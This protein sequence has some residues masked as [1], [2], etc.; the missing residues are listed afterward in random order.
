MRTLIIFL[1]L[2]T[3]SFAQVGPPTSPT[4]E[5][6]HAQ[7]PLT[8]N[9]DADGRDITGV[10]NMAATSFIGDGSG[11]VNV[12]AKL[13]PIYDDAALI[14]S[15]ATDLTTMN[16]A[17]ALDLEDSPGFGDI[18]IHATDS[19]L[20]LQDPDTDAEW[21]WYYFNG[22]VYDYIWF[23]TSESPWL[24]DWEIY[25]LDEANL[26][27][28]DLV[29]LPPTMQ[30]IEVSGLEGD[31]A[32][33]N[34]IYEYGEGGWGQ[35]VET[36]VWG[37]ISLSGNGFAGYT[38][39]ERDET[40]FDTV[41]TLLYHN[42]NVTFSTG[43]TVTT[44][45]WDGDWSSD[46]IT[47]SEDP[48]EE[49]EFHGEGT[50]TVANAFVDIPTL[51]RDFAEGSQYLPRSGMLPMTGDLD[52]GGYDIAGIEDITATG[53]VSLPGVVMDTDEEYTNTVS[54]AGSAVQTNHTGNVEITGTL[55]ASE[56]IG[57]GTT[58][59][60]D[61]LAIAVPNAGASRIL[62]HYG[63]LANSGSL[64]IGIR[65]DNSDRARA[66]FVGEGSGSARIEFHTASSYTGAER[67]RITK[68]GNVGIGTNDPGSLLDVAGTISANDLNVGTLTATESATLNAISLFTIAEIQATSSDSDPV[69]IRDQSFVDKG[70]EPFNDEPV[71]WTLDGEWALWYNS[72]TSKWW[73]SPGPG[74][75]GAAWEG[76]AM[77]GEFT[78]L[79]ATGTVTMTPTNV[80][81]SQVNAYVR[82]QQ[83]FQ[84]PEGDRPAPGA[85][86][87]GTIRYR[88]DG[89]ES[90][91]EAIMQTGVDTY[92]WVTLTTES[93]GM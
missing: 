38:L 75:E 78:A 71:W 20:I 33:Y 88:V 24:G 16:G 10:N 54:L 63:A 37:E 66:E 27:G 77:T 43:W 53:T 14:A 18:Y 57:I 80:R 70:V 2:V 11:L 84:A 62:G 81:F 9:L 86:T 31:F 68:G 12:V 48:L 87:V 1:S 40:S 25:L 17:Y 59:A 55:M 89:D 67:M 45:P 91:L 42:T 28:I 23:N 65:D 47:V 19:H 60:G 49:L 22:D 85:G 73:I 69:T 90:F 50:P 29:P 21:S 32:K 41:V 74:T 82:E 35:E 76:D 72:A 93:W 52:M 5:A 51:T 79:E 56:Q 8:E 64:L 4:V 58:T 44:W 34:G 3:L 36:D 83:Q 39:I 13:V 92:D 61:D 7:N 46:T 15:D 6:R 26:G 30:R